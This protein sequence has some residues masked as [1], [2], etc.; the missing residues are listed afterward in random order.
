MTTVTRPPFSQMDGDLHVGFSVDLMNAIAAELGRTVRYD[1][2]DGF[3]DMLSAVETGKAD[4]AIANIS[5]TAGR[6][7]LFDFSQP[8][9]DSGIQ[10]ML[11]GNR[12]QNFSVLSAILTRE[13]ALWAGAA[14]AVLFGGGILMWFFERGRQSWFDRPASEALFPS[15]WWALNLMLNGGFEERMPNSRM[16]RV[17]AVF[18]V[19]S[20][21]F[22]VSIFVAQITA[23]LTVEAINETVDDLNDLNGRRI[24]TID[25]STSAMFLDQRNMSF[26][27]FAGL[28]PLLKAFESKDLDAVIFDGPILAYYA[29]NSE[30]P[31]QVLDRVYRPENYGIALPAR[32]SLREPIN[33]ALLRLR[34]EGVYQELLLKWFGTIYDRY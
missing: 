21:L 32:S 30:D 13:F 27:G 20:S 18:L 28:D 34:E 11:H 26:R 16:G 25:G 31:V 33:Q 23:A 12:G 2:V 7:A 10:V 22:F 3:G 5:I 15:F 4:A 29:A 1:R 17:F 8:M 19:I 6:E 9:F 24:G 14:L